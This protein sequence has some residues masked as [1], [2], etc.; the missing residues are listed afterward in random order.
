MIVPEVLVKTWLSS[1]CRLTILSLL[2]GCYLS[3]LYAPSL[4]VFGFPCRSAQP[5]N[6][7]DVYVHVDVHARVTLPWHLLSADLLTW[8]VLANPCNS[9]L[10]P[11]N[12]VTAIEYNS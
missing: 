1:I 5:A 9:C 7:P 12:I 3:F 10:Q 6:A 8:Q 11:R 2:I 4:R